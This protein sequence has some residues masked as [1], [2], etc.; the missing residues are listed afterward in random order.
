MKPQTKIQHAVV[1]LSKY[2]PELSKEQENYALQ[3]LFP[4]LA[5][6]TKSSG[7]CLECGQ[8]IDIKKIVRKRVVCDHC[9]E[10][11]KV[12]YT[13][14]RKLDVKDKRFSISDLIQ[15]GIYDFQLIRT[16]EFCTY[17]KKR[18]K[19]R[20]FSWEV[21]QNW[22]DKSGKEVNICRLLS[23]AGKFQG[24]L[25]LRSNRA[26]GYYGYKKN[27]DIAADL[28][29]K[30]PAL[31]PEYIQKGINQNLLSG[32]SLK[33]LI[34]DLKYSQIETV[35][36]A[37]YVDL[38]TAFEIDYVIRFFSSLKICIRNKYKIIDPTLYLDL[39]KALDKLG[40][41]LR[42]AHYV[43]PENLH[44]A[45]NYYIKKVREKEER[46]RL[47][48]QEIIKIEEEKKALRKKNFTQKTYEKEKSK[49]FDICIKSKNIEIKPLL[50][51]KEFQIEGLE[52]DHCVY[53][54][55]YYLK[56]NTLLLSAKVNGVRTETI[57]INLKSFKIL[58][59]R[60]YDNQPSKF[61][62]QIFNLMQKNINKI[63]RA[64]RS[65]P[66]QKSQTLKS[67]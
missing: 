48:R 58:Q 30:E 10:T 42:N 27:Y 51:I 52:L 49:F 20:I 41:D 38:Y 14:K 18:K 45:H 65:K 24:E 53:D 4:K 43:C 50:S 36:K 44:S 5:Y 9:G 63:Q 35:I 12:E 31:R 57:E 32:N 25:T 62:D 56:E 6:A 26:S 21:C 11:L 19:K 28:H 2:L 61:H 13:R 40:L 37:G 60:G 17:Y 39:L 7:F 66:K 47:I 67:A 54:N 3:N 16:F 33:L 34:K 23:W 29:W 46:E 1:E 8:S 15:Y 55:D 64:A 22:Y 59:C